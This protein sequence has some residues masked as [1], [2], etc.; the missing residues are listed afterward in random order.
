TVTI[1]T[2][3]TAD[4]LCWAG[5]HQDTQGKYNCQVPDGVVVNLKRWMEGSPT[6]DGPIHDYRALIINH[7]IG[8]FLGYNHSTC[9]GAGRL[10]P[11]MMQQIKGLHGCIANAWPYDEKGRFVTGPHVQ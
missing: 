3:E 5:I 4:D 2:P 10:A 8:H 7:E 11:V 9:A 6:F 1:A